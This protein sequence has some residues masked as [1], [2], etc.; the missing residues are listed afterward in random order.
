MPIL[1]AKERIGTEVGGRYRLARILGEGGFSAVFLA[2][3]MMTGRRVAL[4]ILHAHLVQEEQI[5]QRFLLEAQ[6]MAKLRHPGITQVLDAGREPDGTVFMAL[7]L[8]EG[9][10][11]EERLSRVGRLARQE[12]VKVVL[13]VLAALAVAHAAEI[14]HRDI[15]PANI[16]LAR[17]ADGSEHAKLLDFGI[18]HVV[19]KGGDKLTSKGVILGTPEYMSPEQG[20]GLGIGPEA[21]LWSVG[22]LM[23]E[24]FSG[25]VPWTHESSTAVLIAVASAQLP[26]IRQFAPDLAEPFIA[27][28]ERAL[29]KEPRQRYPSADAM[30]QSLVEAVR[31]VE[32]KTSAEIRAV[33][34]PVLSGAA[35][36]AVTPEPV[37]PSP[38]GE[39]R[40]ARANEGIA[41]APK[42][43]MRPKPIKD[44][45]F[46]GDDASLE[47][48][49][50]AEAM[51][52]APTRAPSQTNM[53]AVKPSLR[54]A[55]E[56]I[57]IGDAPVRAP[58]VKSMNAPER[59]A[60]YGASENEIVAP[61]TSMRAPP[62]A[63][64]TSNRP[65]S[66]AAAAID[67]DDLP[68]P[69]PPDD[70]PLPPPPRMPAM[71]IPPPAGETGRVSRVPS[72]SPPPMTRT[73]QRAE[74]VKTR[75]PFVVLAPIALVVA[76][77]GAYALY[78]LRPNTGAATPSTNTHARDDAATIAGPTEAGVTPPPDARGTLAQRISIAV[79][80]NVGGEAI[81][82]FGRHVV[83]GSRRA[84]GLRT[85]F[86]CAGD[87]IYAYGAGDGLPTGSGT[88]AIA[89]DMPDIAAIPDVDGDGEDDVAAV[90]RAHDAMLVLATRQYT[91]RASYAVPG[92]YALAGA[93]SVHGETAVVGYT[94]PNGPA[95]ASQLVAIS[96]R[97]GNIL[98]RASGS[99][100]LEKIGHPADVGLAVG[101]DANDDGV[102]DVVA[103]L[104]VLPSL[105]TDRIPA[106]PRCVMLFSGADG[107]PVWPEPFCQLR[108]GSQSVSLGPDLDGDHRAD[109]AIG[110]DQTRGAD[111]RVVIVSGRDGHL[112]RRVI[113]PQGPA[114]PGFG[115]PVNLGPDITGD[116][117][118][119]VAVGSVGTGGSHVTLIS[120]ASGEPVSSANVR[121][122]TGFPNMRV[123]LANGLV[124]TEA[125]GLLVG[126]PDD[127][128]HV[129]LFDPAP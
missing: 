48:D 110:T 99:A 30:R 111:A 13:E 119:D 20:R 36:H 69:P 44:F 55:V 124:R 103:G 1:T 125:P 52:R 87:T 5:A 121:G 33:K 129:Y 6:A 37:R 16:F 81:H 19:P 97:S 8:L 7:E 60:R 109:I 88:A 15:K 89:C 96:A 43:S 14:V 126:A 82:A 105:P 100:P 23:Y 67:G 107:R 102:E 123:V 4:K 104:S 45:E 42:M 80:Y 34:A 58:V 70:L 72:L 79:P 9:E 74:P 54:P 83:V 47:I 75:N 2:E 17:E 116:H 73:Q 127:G 35:M 49:P 57:E 85:M 106:R 90:S 95:G 86:T 22:I 78:R 28:V 10:T 11:L 26:D 32:G 21:D 98:W 128:L 29:Q 3:H 113:V 71:S 112:V 62:S 94:Q 12:T 25:V 117:V 77:I 59:T 41:S 108:G 31:V 40:A 46:D 51:L 63:G 27:I 101:P 65:P 84:N 92:L 38:S 39:M 68:L 93:I 64:T 115:W 53:P 76:G 114:G 56:A 61:K 91:T 122:E 118:P 120:G 50:T 18:A 24:M 66:N